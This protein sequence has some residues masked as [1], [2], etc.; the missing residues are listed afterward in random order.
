[1][2]APVD[3]PLDRVREV[4]QPSRRRLKPV[5]FSDIQQGQRLLD[6][7]Y[8]DNFV[9]KI[10]AFIVLMS[11]VKLLVSEAVFFERIVPGVTGP[12]R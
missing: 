5:G 2:L 4:D 10:V 1:M 9:R 12:G 8:G 7:V 6:C 11:C 3:L